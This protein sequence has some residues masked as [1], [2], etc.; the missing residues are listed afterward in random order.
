MTDL[1]CGASVFGEML[2]EDGRE[3]VR[4]DIILSGQ[5]SVEVVGYS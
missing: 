2:L 5:V 4:G 3:I 1:L